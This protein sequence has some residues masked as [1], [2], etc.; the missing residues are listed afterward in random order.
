MAT[1]GKILVFTGTDHEDLELQY[2]RLRL[3][4]AGYEVVVAGPEAGTVYRGKHG[5]PSRSD[6]AI[7]EVEAFDYR[8]LVLPG[9]WMPDALRRDP[10]VLAITRAMHESKRL[11]ASI[12][13]GPWIA[14]S[15]GVVRG[16]RYTSTPGIRD[17]LVNAG[18]EWSDAPLVIDRH[19]VSSRRPDD[20]PA[21]LRGILEV[22]GEA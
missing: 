15:A 3:I 22:L 14:I 19:H 13:H 2:P 1:K 5:Y 10:K 20:L 12:C 4:E 6:L 18:A 9:G 11:L 7:R 21:F 17:D 8:G 16:Y